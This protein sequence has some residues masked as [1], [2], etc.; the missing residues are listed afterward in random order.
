MWNARDIFVFRVSQSSELKCVHFRKYHLM[1]A[2]VKVFFSQFWWL[3]FRWMASLSLFQF[4]FSISI[5]SSVSAITGKWNNINKMYIVHS[6]G[7]ME[8]TSLTIN[9]MKLSAFKIIF[10]K[11][12]CSERRKLNRIE[13]GFVVRMWL[14]RPQPSIKYVMNRRSTITLQMNEIKW[15]RYLLMHTGRWWMVIRARAQ[16]RVIRSGTTHKTTIDLTRIENDYMHWTTRNH[17]NFCG[18]SAL[19]GQCV[20][21]TSHSQPHII[22]IMNSMLRI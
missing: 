14:A 15:G 8:C 10:S 3:K 6:I 11:I 18:Q 12:V 22:I 21:H 1:I 4:L 5:S 2:L 20:I 16:H 7:R 9:L 17:T 13:T 19:S